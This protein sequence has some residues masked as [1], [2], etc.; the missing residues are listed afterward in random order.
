M[1]EHK[2]KDLLSSTWLVS[3]ERIVLYLESEVMR[4][5]G[6]IPTRGNIIHWIFFL[7][8]RNKTSDANIGII[9]ILV[10]FEKTLL[11]YLL[12]TASRCAF[13]ATGDSKQGIIKTSSSPITFPYVHLN[14]SGGY[15]AKTGKQNHVFQRHM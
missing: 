7:L 15:D 2:F 4:G 12:I 1:H 9:V 8:S 5:P 3:V 10:H 6:S 13:A 11:S 14:T